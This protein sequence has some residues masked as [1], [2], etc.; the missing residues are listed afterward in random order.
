M[1]TVQNLYSTRRNNG[2][3][4]FIWFVLSI[5][6][7]PWNDSLTR[8]HLRFPVIVGGDVFFLNLGGQPKRFLPGWWWW[9]CLFNYSPVLPKKKIVF[10][11]STSFQVTIGKLFSHASFLQQN[12]LKLR[13]WNCK[14]TDLVSLLTHNYNNSGWTTTKKKLKRWECV[15]TAV[16]GY[17]KSIFKKLTI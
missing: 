5:N 14:I 8:A 15:F 17:E 3:N 6:T 10:S 1:K 16:T 2:V 12:T 9:W 11:S 13:N 7:F 4:V